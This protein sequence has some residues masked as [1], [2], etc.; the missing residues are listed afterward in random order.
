MAS[1]GSGSYVLMSEFVDRAIKFEEESAEFYRDLQKQEVGETA[2][3]LL[4][5]LEEQ[6]TE[7]AASLR[8]F[9][10]DRTNET[11]LQFPPALSLSMPAAPNLPTVNQ[12]FDL[13]M[14]REEKSAKIYDYAADMTTGKFKELLD[15]LAEFER[16]HLRSL[17]LLKRS[18]GKLPE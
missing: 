5:A 3:E 15:S 2:L 10:F 6:E 12:L 14:E 8:S 11:R 18:F 9:G 16:G 13:A 4:E 7:H 17:R 1:T